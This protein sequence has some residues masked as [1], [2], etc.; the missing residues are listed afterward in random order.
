M[1]DK[2]VSDWQSFVEHLC[3]ESRKDHRRQ[4]QETI[5]MI[6][7]TVVFAS[8]VGIAIGLALDAAG[9]LR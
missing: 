9:L 4:K 1:G 2:H 7:W 5:G 6:I 3:D 8:A